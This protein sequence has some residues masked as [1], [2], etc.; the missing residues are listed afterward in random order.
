MMPSLRRRVTVFCAVIAVLALLLSW[1][2]ITAWREVG[3]LRHRFTAAQFESFR[4]AGQFQS[5]VLALNSELLA[6]AAGGEEQ[7]WLRFQTDSHELDN[8]FERERE[9]LQTAEEKRVLREIDAEFDHYLEAAQTMRQERTDSSVP[10]AVRF[11]KI[12]AASQ[13]LLT[14]GGRLAD[15]HR[16]ALGDLLGATQRSL[17]LLEMLIGG[18]LMSLLALG[19]WGARVLFHETITPLRSQLIESRALAERHEKL[20]SLG[21]LAAG[22]A[23][24]I[25]NPLTAIKA[26]LFTL[27]RKLEKDKPA[28]HDSAVIDQEISRLER[29]VRDFLLFARPADPERVDV[30]S[31]ELLQAVC[32]LL[33]PELER[34]TIELLVDESAEEVTFRADPQQLKQV[35]INLVRNSAES[36][37]QRGRITLHSRRGRATLAGH[38]QFVVVLEVQDTGA[39]IPPDVQK[40]LF[41]PFFTTKSSG[42]GLGLAIAMRIL[43]K[44]GGTLQFQTEPGRGTTFGLVLPLA[45][46]SFE[47]KGA[48]AAKLAGAR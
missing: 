28:F 5:S 6:Y 2:G 12:E 36:I 24:E 25:R 17:R 4:I 8:W 9:V 11:H 33:R 27:Q 43:E 30:E 38:A 37:E 45:S 16:Q 15:A 3:A 26:R 13:R 1:C 29:I 10:I 40:R 39:G 19:A 34:E 31:R 7:G 23:H 47:E 14:L 22:V 44:H 42:T 20:A 41:D 32:E 35:L 46:A 21:V 18:G 48:P